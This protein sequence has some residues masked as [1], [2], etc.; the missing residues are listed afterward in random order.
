MKKMGLMLRQL[1]QGAIPIIVFI[2][3]I[4]VMG[5]IFT[6]ILT[7][8]A[9]TFETESFTS[10][11]LVLNADRDYYQ[12]LTG[13][14]NLFI[15]PVG[16]DEYNSNADD[17]Y[18]NINDVDTRM[19]EIQSHA[20]SNSE[21]ANLKKSGSNA[22]V[23]AELK[24]FFVLFDDWQVSAEALKDKIESG[25]S[26]ESLLGELDEVSAKFNAARDKLNSIGEA[27][28][29]YPGIISEEAVSNSKNTQL[30]IYLVVGV[31]ALFSIA[32]LF[33][34]TKKLVG[35]ISEIA[36]QEDVLAES[37]TSASVQLSTTSQQLSEGSNEQAASIEETSA[38]MEETSSMVKQNAENTRQANNLAKQTSESATKG[39]SEM[40]EMIKSME[41]LK[42]SSGEISNIIKVIDEIA[43]QTNM[44]ALNA[45]VEAAR[46][47]DAGQGF[48]VVAEEVRNLAQKSAQ[49]AKDTS[50]IIDKNIELSERGGEISE[51]VHVSL[52]EIMEK[53]KNVNQLMDEISAASEEQARGTA[54][55][56]D[57]I[58]QMEKVVQSNAAT[59]EESAA[60]AEELQTQ[61]KTLREVVFRLNNIVKGENKAD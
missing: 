54:Q 34:S 31:V 10:L 5:L 9:V 44:L 36:S 51:E 61:A 15:F 53:S 21:L 2:V 1:F 56:N 30:L 18:G 60:S 46:A 42:K 29:L 41:E 6:G 32:F 20:S 48:A 35:T 59:A 4:I 50:E 7:N 16:S 22:T 38:T 33:F 58:G 40:Q 26:T 12:S 43:F 24:E 14:N 19:R 55:I 8:L 13:Y 45:A 25:K 23:S 52:N 17:F 3:A 11:D 37:L 27:L 39:L 57:A 47:G 28:A 49:A